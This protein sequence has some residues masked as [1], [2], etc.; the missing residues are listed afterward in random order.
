M[1]NDQVS[2]QTADPYKI[3]CRDCIY[4][5]RDTMMINGKKIQTGIMRGTC[6]IFDGKKG[7]WKPMDVTM[8]N[9]NCAFYEQDETAERFWEKEG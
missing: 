7:R 1:I 3:R 8:Y 2:M 6:L 4:R 9:E 5:D